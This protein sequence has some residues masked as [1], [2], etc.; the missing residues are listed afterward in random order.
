VIKG[1]IMNS[2]TKRLGLTCTSVAFNAP[3]TVW[4]I[5]STRVKLQ[6]SELLHMWSAWCEKHSQHESMHTLKIGLVHGV[7]IF[8]ILAVL[9]FVG[10]AANSAL[11]VL[12]SLL[13]TFALLSDLL[14]GYLARKLEVSTDF[15]R[16]LDL[17]ADKSLAIIS[18]LYAAEQG[19]S[20]LPLA[21]IATRDVVMIGMR[22][23]VVDGKQLLP[24]NRI[25][26]GVI[27]SILGANTLLLLNG[28]SNGL[29]LFST[30]VYWFLA[31]VLIGNL[32]NR[33]YSSA[34]RIESASRNKVV[35]D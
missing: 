15:G 14:D 7:S 35:T 1:Q 9:A 26:G 3:S 4:G 2:S 12:V 18:L 21:L 17:V 5:A 28:D 19:I 20:L 31:V 22:V 27:A 24:T 34:D 10:L 16:V 25:F 8:R 23:V 32:L 13:Y 29:F 6:A 30:I 33:L 11:R